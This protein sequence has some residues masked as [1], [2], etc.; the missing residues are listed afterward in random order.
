MKGD[1][2]FFIHIP[3]TAGQSVL[4]A[5]GKKFHPHRSIY[6]Q[7]GAVGAPVFATVRNP[8]DRAVSLFHWYRELVKE[9]RRK[10]E[11][12]NAAMCALACGCADASEFWVRFLGS[13]E[14][15]R[16]QCRYTTMVRPQMFFVSVREQLEEV[17]PRVDRLLRFEQ[18]G[19]D[20]SQMVEDYDLGLGDLPHRNRSKHGVWENELD[21]EAREV[22]RR[23]YRCDFLKLGYEEMM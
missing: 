2:P 4:T 1:R 19:G 13:D 6:S 5:L 10:R 23:H 8:Y 12:H 15:F 22:V 16:Y 11:R 7:R 9:P 21:A 17:S 14:M 18:L 20:W 3:K